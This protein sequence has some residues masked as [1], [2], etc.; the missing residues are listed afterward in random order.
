[1]SGSSEAERTRDSPQN[2]VKKPEHKQTLPADIYVKNTLF[3]NTNS[4][5][6]VE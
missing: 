1:M 4:T 2:L 6:N 3:Y 5:G